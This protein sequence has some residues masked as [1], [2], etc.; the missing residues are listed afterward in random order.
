MSNVIDIVSPRQDQLNKAFQG[1]VD[2]LPRM[3]DKISY[4][5]MG[6]DELIFLRGYGFSP[7]RLV[8]LLVRND[9]GMVSATTVDISVPPTFTRPYVKGTLLDVNDSSVSPEATIESIIFGE[10]KVAQL[11]AREIQSIG[12]VNLDHCT[13]RDAVDAIRAAKRQHRW[14]VKRH[15]G[16]HPSFRRYI[17]GDNLFDE[18]FYQ[19]TLVTRRRIK[20]LRGKYVLRH[21]GKSPKR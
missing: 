17:F 9:R 13:F 11:L 19:Y 6:R 5:R 3:F 15:Q 1:F 20:E 14:D 21:K 8:V 10:L 12:D 18:P 16:A 2:L 7:R 4:H